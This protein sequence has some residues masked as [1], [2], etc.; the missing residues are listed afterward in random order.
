VK[1]TGAWPVFWAVYFCSLVIAMIQFKVPP[2]MGELLGYFHA[3]PVVGGWLMSSASIA[4][5]VLGIP[6][7]LVLRRLGPRKAGALTLACAALGGLLGAVSASIATLLIAR[8][9]EGVG[10]AMMGVIAPTVLAM[11]FP[12]EKLGAPMGIWSTWVPVGMLTVF[13]SAVP[14]S[15]QLN[16]WRAVWWFSAGL[17]VVAL[18]MFWALVRS[19]EGGPIAAGAAQATPPLR[20]MLFNPATWVLAL[21]FGFFG[22]ASQPIVTWIPTYVAVAL[23]V[24]PASANSLAALIS[25][26]LIIGASA[27]GFIIDKTHAPVTILRLALLASSVL[28]VWVFSFPSGAAAPY[29][30][31]LGLLF[32][33]IPACLLTLAPQTMPSPEG[34]GLAIGIAATIKNIGMFVGPIVAGA[35]L[36]SASAPQWS[37]GNW[38]VVALAAAGLLASLALR[39]QRKIAQPATENG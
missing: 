22:A 14:I 9:I 7:A 21:V 18:L 33:I 19:P 39:I 3:T 25:V 20:K 23:G 5:V 30:I 6:A 26:G 16:G 12:R 28:L 4:G 35:A 34:A 27:A 15:T 29:L 32:G 37:V 31:G 8:V 38:L 2:L 13:M 17:C 36:G 24:A 1:K 11:W 10:F